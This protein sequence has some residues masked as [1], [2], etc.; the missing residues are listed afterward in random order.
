MS[1]GFAA[2]AWIAP[3]PPL[4]MVA[5]DSRLSFRDGE[6]SDTGIKTYELGGQTAMVAAGHAMPAIHAA[7]TVRPIVENHNRHNVPRQMGFYDTTRLLAFFL[8]RAASPVNAT[9]EIAVAGFL[10]SEVPAIARIVVSP[11]RN[12]VFFQSV[13]QGIKIA[14]AVGGSGAPS[15]LLMQGFAA[16]TRENDRIVVTGLSLLWYIAQHPAFATIGGGLSVGTCSAPDRYFSWPVIEI[17][18]RRFLRGFDV[19]ESYRPTWPEPIR[20]DYDQTWCIELD[21]R[22]ALKENV[23]IPDVVKVSGYDIDSLSTPD[24]LFQTHDDPKKFILG[25]AVS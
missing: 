19:T 9:C 17:A 10:N 23:V 18:G 1:L 15:N 13:D 7:E 2:A 24:T 25:N 22:I 8:K 4:I 5:A 3:N 21:Q 11:Q 14:M 20:I 6:P 16:S 12:R